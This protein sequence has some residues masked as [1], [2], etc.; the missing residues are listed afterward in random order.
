[1]KHPPLLLFLVLSAVLSAFGQQATTANRNETAVQPLQAAVAALG[2]SAPSDSA[3]SLN[4]ARADGQSGSLI[5]KTKGTSATVERLLATDTDQM[6][7]FSQG[8]A[9]VTANGVVEDTSL[10]SASSSDSC[11]LALPLLSRVLATPDYAIEFVGT[12][13][14]EGKAAT[15]I[16]F[17]NVFASQPKLAALERFTTK[18]IWIDSA[19]NLPVRIS[20]EQRSGS[21]AVAGIAVQL[22]FSN[23]KSA[24][25]Y[26]LPYTI[27][28]SFN[29]TYWGT[30]T[31]QDA[32]F[33]SGLTDAEFSVD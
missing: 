23:Y 4:V 20:Y 1:M 26:T 32:Q 24:S 16:R 17:R 21:G 11:I 28:R 25:G 3:I 6:T 14:I 15:H 29:G 9:K 8:V 5:V 30:L 13:S 31:I 18:D 22:D 7:V 10:E 2:G 27:K 33:N 12:E 19:T